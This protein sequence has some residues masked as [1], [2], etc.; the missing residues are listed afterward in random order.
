MC[1]KH[2]WVDGKCQHGPV[3]EEQHDLPWFD[4]RETDFQAL[5]EVIL[6]PRLLASLKYY[7]KFR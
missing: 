1:N 6:A 5:Q 2:E 3:D 7:V 4:R